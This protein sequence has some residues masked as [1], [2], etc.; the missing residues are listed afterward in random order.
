M[1]SISEIK[2]DVDK[3]YAVI[4]RFNTEG[5]IPLMDL[6][7]PKRDGVQDAENVADLMLLRE[8]LN[9]LQKACEISVQHISEA[10]E[11]DD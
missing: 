6:A 10:I 8:S 7:Y 2:K 1:K 3:T 9:S 5:V 4:N 11:Q